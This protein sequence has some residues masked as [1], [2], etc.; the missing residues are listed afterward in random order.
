MS[1]LVDINSSELVRYNAN[2]RGNNTS[3]CVKRAMSLGF[4]MSYNEMSKLLLDNQKKLGCR[5]WNSIKCY[6]HLIE[7][8][9]GKSSG[10]NLPANPDRDGR[11]EWTLDEFIDNF[12]PDGTFL[13]ETGRE[14]GNVS[15][16]V[17]VIDHKLYDSWDSRDRFVYRYYTLPK[18]T[19]KFTDIADHIKELVSRAKEVAYSEVD[20]L[21]SKYG[22]QDSVTFSI[23]LVRIKSGYTIQLNCFIVF[24]PCEYSAED[25]KYLFSYAIPFT[26]TTTIDE[27]DDLIQKITKTRIYDRFY[28]IRQ[29]EAKLKEAYDTAK[30]GGIYN[31]DL[32]VTNQE[33]R[34]IRSLP[35]W[36]RGVL[37][38]INIER[39]GVYNDSYV[40]RIN[41]LPGDVSH[42]HDRDFRFETRTSDQMKAVL[43]RYHD[44]FEVQYID[45]D[46]DPYD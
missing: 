13:V 28:A 15:H 42:P 26:P 6:P 7:E 12:L 43:K 41:K 39:P 21:G 8:L 18:V 2:N 36:V 44:T 33:E 46:F 30:S 23:H 11:S 3:D 38:Y 37:K 40:I 31:D 32:W 5:S 29:Q 16:I 27:A 19:R 20:K 9:G 34:F 4:N 35:G 17:C 1:N 22:W 45:Y 14:P 25:R 24:D 10:K